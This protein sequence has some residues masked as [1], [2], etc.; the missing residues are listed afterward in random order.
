[1]AIADRNKKREIIY[2]KISAGEIEIKNELEKLKKY[3]KKWVG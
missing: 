2:E 1:M 3:L